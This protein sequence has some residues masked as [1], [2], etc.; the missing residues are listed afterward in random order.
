[1][2]TQGFGW[3]RATRAAAAAGAMLCL[4]GC[5]DVELSMD[6]RDGETVAVTTTAV[7]DRALYDLSQEQGL[8][9]RCPLGEVTLTDESHTCTRPNI[10]AI[11]D[12]IADQG[13]PYD[14]ETILT[15]ERGF[16]LTEDA[17]GT[18]TV[19]HDLQAI[20]RSADMQPP[21]QEQIDQMG[22]A[23]IEALEGHA[24]VLSV[25]A[26]EI[27]ETTGVLSADGQTATQTIPLL[28]LIEPEASFASFV[29]TVALAEE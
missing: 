9:D 20:F 24:I 21:T 27:V 13:I 16:T 8:G 26:P 19:T 17:P 2:N 15:A 22:P 29:T 28:E 1:M 11:A 3:H 7:M 14:D 6:F 4:S 5:V 10:V 12:L 25:S 18:F 23:L